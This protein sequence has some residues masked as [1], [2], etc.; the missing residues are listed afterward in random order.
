MWFPVKPVLKLMPVSRIPRL[1]AKTRRHNGP[2]TEMQELFYWWVLW[3]AKA[4]QGYVAGHR[5]S[6]IGRPGSEL[7]VPIYL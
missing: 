7:G 4:W 6:G 3:D 5:V 1:G 2:D